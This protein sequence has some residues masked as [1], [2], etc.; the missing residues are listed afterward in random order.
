MHRK[1]SS[2]GCT[3]TGNWAAGAW[4]MPASMG[5][6]VF[7]AVRAYLPMPQVLTTSLLRRVASA[8]A[9]ARRAWSSRIL[10]SS[11]FTSSRALRAAFSITMRCIRLAA[12]W[13]ICFLMFMVVRPCMMIHH[14]GARDDQDNSA[15]SDKEN[16]QRAGWRDAR[17]LLHDV[18]QLEGL[19]AAAAK[20][21]VVC[22]NQAAQAVQPGW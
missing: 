21:Q 4:Y 8:S 20:D 12:S 10:R 19:P 14:S 5:L 9:F 13:L 15:Q 22:T 1:P 7:I 18:R 6:G 3:S 11:S 2:L 17:E 16:T